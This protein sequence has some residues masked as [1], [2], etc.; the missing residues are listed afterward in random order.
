M[1][2]SGKPALLQR[3]N[4]S[5]ILDLIRERGPISRTDVARQLHLSQATVTR[6]VQ[7]LLDD[8]FLIEVAHGNSVTGRKPILLQF[9][10]KASLIVGVDQGGTKI[11]GALADLEGE[12]LAWQ[13]VSYEPGND[14][15]RRLD[16]LLAVIADLL[17]AAPET[18]GDGPRTIRGIGIGVPGVVRRDGTV[19][20]AP[21][22]GWRDLPLK[23]IVKERFGIPTFVENDTNLAALGELWFGAGKG[24]RNLIS[25]SVGTGIGA[26]L[27]VDGRLYRG[28]TD[29]AGEI[30]YVVT[31]RTQLGR[32]FDGF[33]PLETLASGPAITERA[34][35]LLADGRPSRMHDLVGGDLSSLTAKEVC[36]AAREGDPTAQ[37]IVSDTASTLAIALSN[38][39]S[40]FDPDVVILNGG[41]FRSADLFLDP[42]RQR[43][44][45]TV[46]D[47][48]PIVVSPLGEDAVVKGAIAYAIHATDDFVFV[49]A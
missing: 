27:I 23:Q 21:A 26:G 48:P 5:A 13:R 11:A 8:K 49:T 34:R 41:V 47:L 46:P 20:W 40:L 44:Q 2:P 45:G 32:T 17:V 33:G 3:I 24:L 35:A 36:Q 15:A 10:Y 4:K 16:K 39:I 14:R 28:R 9:N 7:K 1:P 18:N 43:L 25:I 37:Q 19:V 38:A 30:G 42:I 12:L 31:D 22:L 29:S 6:I